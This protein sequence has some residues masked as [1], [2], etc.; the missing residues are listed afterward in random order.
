MLMNVVLDHLTGQSD[1]GSNSAAKTRNIRNGKVRQ[2]CILIG[3]IL[4]K[5]L[6]IDNIGSGEE[7]DPWSAHDEN[8]E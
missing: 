1:M 2:C 8:D 5:Y 4:A 7:L 3:P 6:D